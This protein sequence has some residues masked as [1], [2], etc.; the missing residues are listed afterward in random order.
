MSFCLSEEVL[1]WVCENI[2]KESTILEL[3]SGETTQKLIEAGYLMVSVEHDLSWV[4]KY[5]SLYIYAP[6]KGSWYDTT[7]LGQLKHISYELIIVDGPPAHTVETR[8]RRLGFLENLGLFDSSKPIIVDDCQRPVEAFL[9]EQL[10]LQLKR[11]CLLHKCRDGKIFGVI[12][13]Q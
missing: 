5:G 2:P 6:L 11:P 4:N 8:K 13:G 9:L 1:Q 3:G 12:E 7:L 10:R